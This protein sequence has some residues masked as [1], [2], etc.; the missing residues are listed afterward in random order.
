MTCTTRRVC[1]AEGIKESIAG[2]SDS[3]EDN[4]FLVTTDGGSK[5]VQ[6]T[7][8][9]SPGFNGVA[10]PSQGHCVLVGS[11]ESVG[12]TPPTAVIFTTT[13]GGKRWTSEPVPRGADLLNAVSCASP[14]KCVVVGGGSDPTYGVES[15]ILTSSDGGRT[16]TPRMVPSSMSA[17]LGSVS[18]PT[19]STCVATGGSSRGPSVAVTLDGGVTWTAN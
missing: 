16:W 11:M 8:G 13:D 12:D 10:C 7:M 18:C 15:T 17:G 6:S 4:D 9:G 19:V 14:T 5:W 1:L 3:G 2:V